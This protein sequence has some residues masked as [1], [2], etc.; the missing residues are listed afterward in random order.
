MMLA[1]AELMATQ[2]WIIHQAQGIK[3]TD[4]KGECRKHDFFPERTELKFRHDREE[5]HTMFE[6]TGH[7]YPQIRG[8]KNHVRIRSQNPFAGRGACRQMQACTLPYQSGGS[9]LVLNSALA[10]HF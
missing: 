10:G 8:M 5:L 4:K 7:C 6:G 2:D 1:N 3:G 9:S